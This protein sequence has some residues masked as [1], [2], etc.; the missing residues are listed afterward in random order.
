MILINNADSLELRCNQLILT[1]L[2]EISREMDHP[3]HQTQRG[4]GGFMKDLDS[5]AKKLVLVP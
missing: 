2:M 4:G 3:G 1:L 5:L